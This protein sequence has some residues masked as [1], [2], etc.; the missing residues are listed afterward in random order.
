MAFSV[1]YIVDLL[2]HHISSAVFMVLVSNFSG[3]NMPLL[4][5]FAAGDGAKAGFGLGSY[6][7]KA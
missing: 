2:L 4:L 1:F 7:S 5:S 3:T 6:E